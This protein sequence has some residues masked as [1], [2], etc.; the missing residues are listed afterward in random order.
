MHVVPQA[1]DLGVGLWLGRFIFIF[2]CGKGGVGHPFLFV[3][4]GE[5]GISGAWIT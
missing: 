4:E 1:W 3:I 2:V 5:K